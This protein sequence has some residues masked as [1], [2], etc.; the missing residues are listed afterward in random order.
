VASSD[1]D[2][3]ILESSLVSES[4]VVN[5]KD[6]VQSKNFKKKTNTGSFT[7]STFSLSRKILKGNRVIEWCKNRV[8]CMRD[9]VTQYACMTKSHD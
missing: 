9:F 6:H 3:G 7:V 4:T 1:S 2:N 5:Q 8:C